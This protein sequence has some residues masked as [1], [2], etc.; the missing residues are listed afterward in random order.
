MKKLMTKRAAY[1]VV[2]GLFSLMV[3]A[4][5]MMYFVQ[6]DMVVE[7]FT[8]LGFPTFI[9]YPLAIAKLL[10]LVAILTNKSAKL[11]EWAYAGFF[12]DFVLA[13][14]AHLSVGDGEQAGAIMALV[15]ML[16][17]YVLSSKGYREA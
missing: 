13:I 4:G 10:G 1:W 15:L 12:F 8:N 2:T 7:S 5:A 9:V 11:K 16:G 17:S 14:S 6:N 3:A